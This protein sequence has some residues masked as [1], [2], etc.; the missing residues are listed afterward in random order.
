MQ[1]QTHEA[2]RIKIQADNIFLHTSDILRA[3]KSVLIVTE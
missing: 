1:L 3:K 2:Q